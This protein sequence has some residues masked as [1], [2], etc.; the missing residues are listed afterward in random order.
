MWT[1]MRCYSES[2]ECCDMASKMCRGGAY[3]NKTIWSMSNNQSQICSFLLK[4]SAWF[5]SVPLGAQYVFGTPCIKNLAIVK[6]FKK[7]L[8]WSFG[9]KIHQIKVITVSGWE[10][11]NAI[12]NM[13]G[14]TTKYRFIL[15]TLLPISWYKCSPC[16]GGSRMFDPQR[17]EESTNVFHFFTLIFFFWIVSYRHPLIFMSSQFV[18]Q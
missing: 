13:F 7:K 10:L 2:Q 9:D 16:D 17:S 3:Q 14:T 1:L 15:Y 8:A 12:L 4:M 18:I 5:S 11:Y 6:R